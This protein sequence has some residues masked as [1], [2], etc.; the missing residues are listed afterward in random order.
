M[1]KA[2]LLDNRRTS[3]QL[4]Y[5]NRTFT[6]LSYSRSQILHA[7]PRKFMLD[8]K[9]RLRKRM[10]SGTFAYGH[11]VG[12]GIQ[13]V[14]SGMSRDRALMF[15]IL[16][17]DYDINKFGN[18]SE[19]K[20]NKSLWHALAFVNRFYYLY[21]SGQISYLNGW[22]VATFERNGETIKGVELTFVVGLGDGHTYEGHIDLVLYN[23]RKNRYMVLEL[24]TTN[25][26]RIDEATYRNSAQPI[27]Y[28]IIIDNIAGNLKASSS[29]DVLYMIGRSK[30][31]DIIPMPFTK[32][33]ADKAE[34]LMSILVDKQTVETF[35][36]L[37][38]YPKRGESCFSYFRRCDYYLR[39]HLPHDQLKS[40]EY[41]E[42][43][44]EVI[45][46]ELTDPTFMFTIDELLDRQSQ[47]ESMT[48]QSEQTEV[49]MLLDVRVL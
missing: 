11:A 34:V 38:Y 25:A 20:S 46:S 22:E 4:D 40:E 44:D 8:S 6:G 26:N 10:G 1:T 19:Q 14:L 29:F 21:T 37:E 36:E 41:S 43:D 7:C 23:P 31:Q 30:T 49:D 27:I 42:S 24:K 28:G 48:R 9:Y 3:K 33:P 39:C 5:Y 32:T 47:I 35:E 2:D 45:Y 17:Y 12:S 15:T 13:A 18:E 16:E